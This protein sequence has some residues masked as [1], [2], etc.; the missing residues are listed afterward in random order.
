MMI[1]AAA[2]LLLAVELAAPLEVVPG[3]SSTRWRQRRAGAV[4]DEAADVRPA[5]FISIRSG[6]GRSRG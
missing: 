3:G 5:T 1:G 4:A 6:A 2:C